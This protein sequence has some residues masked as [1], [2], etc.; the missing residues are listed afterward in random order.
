LSQGHG[1]TLLPRHASLL[2]R[3]SCHC[4]LCYPCPR[5]PVTHVSGLYR[6]RAGVR[7]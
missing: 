1:G 6:E 3:F 7:A 4:L 5:T 2:K